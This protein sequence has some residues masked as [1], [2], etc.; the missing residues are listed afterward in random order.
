MELFFRKFGNGPAMIILHGL[1][2]SSDNWLTVG[3]TLSLSFEVFLPVLRNH[4]RSPH[5]KEHNYTVLKNDLYEFMK[6]QGLE[7]A[8]II[9]HSMGGKA[10]IS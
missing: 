5:T 7:K 1:Y 8:V 2:G 6:L 9:G 3:K 4:G 10:A